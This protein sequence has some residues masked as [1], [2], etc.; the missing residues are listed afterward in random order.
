M[1]TD[2]ENNMMNQL[3]SLHSIGGGRFL[4]LL[5]LLVHLQMAQAVCRYDD[6]SSSDAAT[7]SAALFI[8]EGTVVSGIEKISVIPTAKEKVKKK[9]RRKGSSISGKAKQ[10]KKENFSQPVKHSNRNVLT[11]KNDN[12]SDQ[13]LLSISDSDKQIVIPNQ[14]TMKFLMPDAENKIPALVHLLDIFL[15][16]VYPDQWF[17][18]LN[19]FRHFNRPPP[20]IPKASFQFLR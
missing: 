6:T 8:S 2:S 15:K 19:L 10:K 18:D 14:H 7:P 4:L 13:S 1:K 20:F 12:Q 3:F 16:K 11:F 17:S 5:L 9:H